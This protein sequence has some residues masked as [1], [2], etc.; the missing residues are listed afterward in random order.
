MTYRTLMHILR[1]LLLH[2]WQLISDNF[3]IGLVVEF[4]GKTS[5]DILM[6]CSMSTKRLIRSEHFLACLTLK[7]YVIV[8]V[9]LLLL[10]LALLIFVFIP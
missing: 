3:F 5:F 2:H 1:L 8:V 4:R 7:H 9:V 10:L 6:A